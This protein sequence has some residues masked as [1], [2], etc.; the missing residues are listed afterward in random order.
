V[1]RREFITLLGGTLVWP[2]T[3]RAQQ[4]TMPVIGFL[5]GSSPDT[6]PDLVAAFRKGLHKSGYLEGQN[7]TIEYSWANGQ[8]DRLPAL[9][10]ELA[11]R[12]VA[13]IVVAGGTATALAAKAATTTI[14]IIFAI[15]A[16]PVRAGLVASINRPDRNLTG[17]SSI[18]DQVIT[19]RLEL[20]SELVAPPAALA[21]LVNPSNPNTGTRSRDM[22]AAARALGRQIHVFTASGERD[23]DVAFTSL[24]QQRIGGLVVQ[25]DTFF[26][27]RREQIVA[28][29]ARHAVPA[30]YEVREF[31]AAG[32]LMSYGL[33]QMDT[34]LQVGIYAGRILNGEKPGDLPVQFPTKFELVINLKTAKE[35]GLTIPP[36]IM[37]RADEILWDD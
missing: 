34:Y 7:L 22:Q 10:T 37:V 20:L 27:R 11:R 1:K 26:G 24:S 17:F 32:G 13:L 3:G 29:A 16:D 35:L 12:Q 31:A 25:Y 4:P 30:I 28:L 2:L 9:A 19:K 33:H 21:V 23:L 8:Y 36:S 15:G 5:S 14:P 18:T 6:Y